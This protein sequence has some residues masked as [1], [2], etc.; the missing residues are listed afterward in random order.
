MIPDSVDSAR[1]HSA[2]N[3]SRS[4][5]IEI[6][7]GDFCRCSASQLFGGGR[8]QMVADQDPGSLQ[9]LVQAPLI[10]V[11]LGSAYFNDVMIG[12]PSRRIDGWWECPTVIKV[13]EIT[14]PWTLSSFLSLVEY[15]WGQYSGQKSCI[16]GSSTSAWRMVYSRQLEYEK[17]CRSSRTRTT[18]RAE[19]C[20]QGRKGNSGQAQPSGTQRCGAQNRHCS[21]G[22]VERVAL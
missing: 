7:L 19:G 5:S 9:E 16:S 17:N 13:D 22:Q 14:Q 6:L 20:R 10:A 1:H 18:R 2:G 3:R 4:H 21:L 15:Y 11:R 8:T 12:F